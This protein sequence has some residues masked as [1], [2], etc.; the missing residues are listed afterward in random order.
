MSI[1]SGLA[2]WGFSK[3]GTEAYLAADRRREF[4]VR[5]PIIGVQGYRWALDH[6]QWQPRGRYTLLAADR[7]LRARDEGVKQVDAAFGP[8]FYDLVVPGI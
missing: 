6:N 3:G 8:R 2:S 7:G 4:G 5:G 1:R